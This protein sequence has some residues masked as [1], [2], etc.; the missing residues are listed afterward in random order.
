MRTN[1]EVKAHIQGWPAF[2]FFFVPMAIGWIWIIGTIVK[3][4]V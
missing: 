1:R 2:I 3:A 4:I